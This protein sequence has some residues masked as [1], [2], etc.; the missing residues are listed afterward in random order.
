MNILHIRY[1]NTHMIRRAEN[2]GDIGNC[3]YIYIYIVYIYIYVHV[4][5]LSFYLFAYLSQFIQPY[6]YIH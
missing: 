6:L 3:K 4:D 2:Y 5:S 1:T